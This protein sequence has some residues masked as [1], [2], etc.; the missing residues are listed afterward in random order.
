MFIGSKSTSTILEVLYV[1]I[2]EVIPRQGLPFEVRCV[3]NGCEIFA[4][5]ADLTKR[6][7]A[8]AITF[9]TVEGA[10]LQEL[11]AAMEATRTGG[12]VRCDNGSAIVSVPPFEWRQLPQLL[13]VS[14]MIEKY[15]AKPLRSQ[16]WELRVEKFVTNTFNINTLV[17]EMVARKAS[18]IHLRAGNRPFL[19]ID[20]DLMAMD[21]PL[22]S[23]EDM[24][25][26]VM[27]L[28][29]QAELDRLETEKENSFQYHAA[30]MGYLRCSGYI[31]SGAMALGIRLIP[32]EPIP[33]EQLNIPEAVRSICRAHRGLFLVCGITGSGKSTTLAAMVDYINQVRSAHIIT[34]ED[35][36]EFVYRDKKSIVSQ[37]QVGRDTFSFANALRGALR[38]DPDVIL[39]GEMRDMETIRAALSAAETGHLVLSTLH[40]TTAVDTVNRIISYFPQSER[41]LIR[42]ELAYTLRGVVCQRLRKKIGGGR[43][44]CVEILLGGKPIVRDAIIDGDLDK[45]YGIIEVDPDMKSFDQY[46]VDLFKKGLVTKEEAISACANEE[47]LERVISGIK[48]S[49][50]RRLLK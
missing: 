48:S 14:R 3:T 12:R 5:S 7:E 33:F 11:N 40:T 29:G 27:Q 1:G 44:P 17:E 46:A 13:P 28:G 30:G 9:P 8:M 26:I 4:R 19:R 24:H 20:N 38:E 34:T 45:L 31:K 43:I 39:V 10:S 15:C 42:Q 37:R 23:S 50:G 49:E 6:V 35:P 22:I 36:V 41:D 2:R 16:T 32:E 18:D 47:G 25:E 21:L